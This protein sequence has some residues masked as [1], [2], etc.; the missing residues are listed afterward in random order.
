M[1]IFKF[2]YV[3]LFILAA[4]PVLG[5]VRHLHDDEENTSGALVVFVIVMLT[6]FVLWQGR[7]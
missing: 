3:V 7:F 2:L 1:S 5:Y 6:G 4:A